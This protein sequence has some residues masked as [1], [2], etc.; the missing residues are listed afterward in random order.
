MAAE[1]GGGGRAGSPEHELSI[2]LYLILTLITCGIYNLYWNYRQMQACNE[3][4][5]REE[6]SW[7]MWFLLSLVTCGVYHLFYQYKMGSVIVEIQRQSGRPVFDSL[8]VV[9]ILVTLFGGSVIVDV[10]HQYEINTL[11]G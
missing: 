2:P 8:P 9:S 7:P 6:F 10:I 4:V 1:P 11:C 5:G 3:M